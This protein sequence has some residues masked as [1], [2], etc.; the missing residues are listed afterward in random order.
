EELLHATG[1]GY[2]PYATQVALL[3]GA[4]G[5]VALFLARFSHRES[6]GSFVFDAA[7]LAAVQ[8]ITFVALEVGERLASGASLHDLAQGNL[9]ALGIS[10]QVA[11]AVVGALV[12]RAT[13]RF[14]EEADAR[15]R[16]VPLPL[17]RPLATVAA[18]PFVAPR[19]PSMRAAA[20]RAPPSL[21]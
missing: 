13:D 21:H 12:L 19:R 20:S 7:I 5:L 16:V 14:A 18:V 2:L 8:S 17:P 1:H 10:V 11:M 3:A 6:R 15:S 4:I 9:L